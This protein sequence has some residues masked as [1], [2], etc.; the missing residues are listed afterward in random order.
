HAT[1]WSRCNKAKQLRWI[2][3]R[4]SAETK[5]GTNGVQSATICRVIKRCIRRERLRRNHECYETYI[6]RIAVSYCCVS[7]CN[8]NYITAKAST[9][10]QIRPCACTATTRQISKY[11]AAG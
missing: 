5:T 1:V 9:I 4:V 11:T 2:N 10:G 3:R 8:G 6:Y 7:C